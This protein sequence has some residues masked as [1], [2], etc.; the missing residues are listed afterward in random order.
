MVR[1]YHRAPRGRALATLGMD[2]ISSF[3]ASLGASLGEPLSASLAAALAG[4]AI[5]RAALAR[6]GR[7]VAR[8]PLGDG[9]LL[10]R[11]RGGFREMLVRAD[12]EMIWTRASIAEPS[13]S[14][15]AYVDLFHLAAALA[16]ERRTALFLGC[17]GGVAIRQFAAV[18]PGIAMD[19]VEPEPAVL[20]LAERC[21]GLG[22]IPGLRVHLG[23][24]A[25]FVAEAARSGRRWDV[26]IV[27]AYGA[28][29]LPPGLADR[30]FFASLRRCLRPGGAMA[31]NV[32]GTIDGAGVVGAASAALEA[33]FG[34]ARMV[35]VVEPGEGA[36]P[37]R[38]RNVV[39]V[40]R[41]SPG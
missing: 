3:A 13:A 11:D 41:R 25:A 39:L 8:A 15:W 2:P 32:V 26:A 6:R 22:D 40:A 4:L 35:P 16:S 36:S 24:G 5:A 37:S 19:V 33:A 14:G 38:E 20:S 17:G 1:P 29:R 9:E 34:N 21:F 12:H 7:V 31:L 27:D 30:P 23:E 18:Y 10:V 28:M